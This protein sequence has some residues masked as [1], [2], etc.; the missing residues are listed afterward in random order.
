M[1]PNTN[2]DFMSDKATV[3]Y[4]Q[5][6]FSG[7]QVAIYIGDV[8]VDEV[9]SLAVS[10]TQ[11]KQPIYGYA[12]QLY[13][14]VSRGPLIVAGSFAINFKEA[15]Y[16]WAIL[17][18]YKQK[19]G[20]LSPFIQSIDPENGRSRVETL[21]ANIERIES[22]PKGDPRLSEYFN[23]LAGFA[24][25][26]QQGAS[27]LDSA[28]SIFEAFEDAVWGQPQVQLDAQT[29]RADD[30]RLNGFD[31]YVQ[32]GDWSNELANHTVYKIS[33]VH[34]T[35]NQR[36]IDANGQPVQEMY[37]FIARNLV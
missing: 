4:D 24:S 13:N 35:G 28:E 2:S 25:E 23:N 3:V 27:G 21:R 9:T 20:N 11:T 17:N 6:Y 32:F 14:A 15:G 1:P 18:R 36:Q 19:G 26:A 22:L 7:A 5:E 16:L 31:I 29:R 10:V 37:S 34:I 30:H 12:S 8:W 33:D